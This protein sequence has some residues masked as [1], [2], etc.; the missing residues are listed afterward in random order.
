M[1]CGP[2]GAERRK[3]EEEGG[4]IN[5]AAIVDTN[6]VSPWDSKNLYKKHLRMV[7]LSRRRKKIIS[8]HK[9]VFTL[10]TSG[11]ST[12]GHLRLWGMAEKPWGRKQVVQ[13]T[14]FVTLTCLR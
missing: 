10:Q 2:R 8:L 13:R 5:L 9:V 4:F 12:I 1:E 3:A 6:C 14:G 7:C 11:L